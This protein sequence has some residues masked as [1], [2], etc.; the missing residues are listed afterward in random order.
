[1]VDLQGQYE[2]IKDEVNAA[3]QEVIDTTS[4]VR[5]PAVKRFEEELGEYLDGV[6]ALG[7]ASGT[8]ALQ[9]AMMAL[10]IGRGDQVITT[11]FTFIATAEAA[12]LLGAE[13]VFVDID[14]ETYNIDVDRVEEAITGDTKAIVPVHLFG[15]PCDMQP[16]LDLSEKHDLPI[17]EDCAQSINARYQNRQTGAMGTIGCLSFFPSKNLGAFGD[18]GAVL[19]RNESIYRKMKSIANHGAE[20]KYHHQR[21]GINSRLDAIQAAVLRI[22]LHHLDKYTDARRRAAGR[23]DALLADLDTVITPNRADDRRHVFHQYTIK[24]KGPDDKT[25]NELS[26]HLG[27]HDIPHAV[28]YPKPL[29]H[30]PVFEQISDTVPSLPVAERCSEQVLS[31]PMHTELTAEEQETVVRAIKDFFD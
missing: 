1:M 30:L 2:A 12:A 16:L 11:P 10:D 15:Q 25:R 9:I 5:G 21:V 27:A 20:K 17:I 19:T 4:F 14:P 13:P 7:V 31:L 26:D 22:K 3:I 18:G 6:H 23:Y 28:Y 8:D 24:V 29:H